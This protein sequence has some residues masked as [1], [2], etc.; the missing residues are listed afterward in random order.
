MR[1]N[2]QSLTPEE[3]G[4]IASAAIFRAHPKR[5]FSNRLMLKTAR[6]A[7]LLPLGNF[8]RSLAKLPG[9]QTPSSRPT[10]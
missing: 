2:H 4:F 3:P 10:R 5:G 6:E 1:L 7:G 9:A 8:D